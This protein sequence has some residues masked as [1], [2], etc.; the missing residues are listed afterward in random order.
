MQ[1][2]LKNIPKKTLDFFALYRSS[3]FRKYFLSGGI[4]LVM[5]FSIVSVSHG[6]VDMQGL[7]ASVANVSEVP[8]FDADL[9][10]QRD[11][12]N[13]SLIFGANAKKVDKIDFTIL[14]DPTRFRS[15][16]STNIAVHIIGDAE[17]GAY[18]VNIDMFGKDILPW[19][20]IADLTA[21]ID[22]GAPIALTDTQFVSGGQRYTITSKW[23]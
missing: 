18:H 5:A 8:H 22:T 21:T 3:Q 9:I 14:S 15:L 23:E 2:T 6:D 7:M 17:M 16:K 11:W 13:I 20:R 1:K 10:L 12:S 4:A 19:T